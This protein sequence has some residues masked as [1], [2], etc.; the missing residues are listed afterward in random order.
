MPFTAIPEYKLTGKTKNGRKLYITLNDFWYLMPDGKNPTL[1]E[2]FVGSGF[3]TDLASIPNF[4]FMLKPNS[5]LW[6]SAAIVHDAA[7]NGVR[8]GLLTYKDADALLYYAMIE[9]GSTK[10][11]AWGFWAYVSLRHKL[12]LEKL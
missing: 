3:V 12:G 5:S 8:K 7:C 4:L 10:L 6:A 2:Y 1:V 11:L 9:C